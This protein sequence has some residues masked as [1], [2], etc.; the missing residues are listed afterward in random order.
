MVS[1]G[2]GTGLLEALLLKECSHITLKVIEASK[3][4]NQY[5]R[6]EDLHVVRGTWDA[7]SLVADAHR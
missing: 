2:S 3:T 5:M 4:A 1:I 6:E 7:C